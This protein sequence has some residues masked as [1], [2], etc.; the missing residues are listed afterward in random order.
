MSNRTPRAPRRRPQR[1]RTPAPQRLQPSRLALA[2][3][4][5]SGMAAAP[6]MAQAEE[7]A[8]E[9][10]AQPAIEEVIV[11]A[12]K[13]ESSIQDTPVSIQALTADEIQGLNISRFEDFAEQ[14][15]SISYISVGP[16]SQIMHIRGVADG[17]IPHVGRVNEAT[18]AYYLDE[19][20]AAG[21]RGGP[22]DIALYDLDR[23]EVLR[24]PEGTYYGASAVSG[25][26]RIITNKPNPE[27]F[28]YG[29]DLAGGSIA[30]GE[31]TY[32][33]KAFVNVPL[34]DRAAVRAVVWHQ[35]ENGFVDNVLEERTYR[36]GVTVSNERYAEDDY[37]KETTT[38]ARLALAV[39]LT[40]TWQAMLSGFVDRM[41]ADG[42]WDHDPTRRGDLEVARF[43]PETVDVDT[44]QIAFTLTGETPI[45]DLVYASSYYDRKD[46]AV[47][48]YS[49][50]VEYAS[51][52]SW[53]QSYACEDFYWN[54]WVG[55]MDPSI[56][57]SHE[58][59][60]SRAAHE[61]RLSS[62]TE[63]VSRLSWLVGAYHERSWNDGH[64]FWIMPNIN[65]DNGPGGAA[66]RTA[67]VDPLPLE[68]W[69][70][71]QW[72]GEDYI[73]AVFGD[74]S[75]DFTERL[76]VSAGM[77]FFRWEDGDDWGHSCGYGWETKGAFAR[78][79]PAPDVEEQTYKVNVR[80]DLTD[81]LLVYFGYGEGVRPGFRNPPVTHD[82]VPTVVQTDYTESYEVGWKATL[83]QGRVHLNGAIYLIDWDNFQTTLYD[84]LTVPFEFRRN[85][86]GSQIRGAEVDLVAN[87]GE[88]WQLRGG[89]AYNVAELEGDFATIAREPRFVYAEDGRRLAHTPE[90]GWSFSASYKRP[91]A[92]ER[93]L[94]SRAAWSYT[95]ERWNL[96]ARQSEQPP[97]VMDAYS[98]L[99]LRGGIDFGDWAAEV[100]VTNATDE[101][102]E[103]FQNSG[104]YDPRVTTIQPRTIGVRFIFGE[105]R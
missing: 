6:A 30:H 3:A 77:R 75:W 76:T 66:A 20:P 67:G 73:S 103:I 65:F 34:S 39:D 5:A 70:C 2:I 28:D 25:T 1:E 81:N 37:N 15:P 95:D 41:E 56:T 71:P 46:L 82:E 60:V 43:A 80:Y 22:P 85:V 4:A 74:V 104:Y 52:G 48:D 7:Q 40:D 89:V 35:Q 10:S 33:G 11:T 69:S 101:R 94:Y 27:A 62:K 21:R 55:C 23:I 92:G 57:F 63:D 24:G 32:E 31:T 49:D 26:V 17:G 96:L 50:Y 59:N 36:N 61:V 14:T 97:A 84:L 13:R 38:G 54:G 12:R 98:L 105:Q 44:S 58:D 9:E 90:W 42:A 93:E 45:G 64:V 86:A 53:V 83:A 91:L 88:S 99:Q 29:A 47:N 100:F 68:W 102:A 72:K 16:G 51:F 87:I 8:Q 78:Q 18:T 19:H 79:D